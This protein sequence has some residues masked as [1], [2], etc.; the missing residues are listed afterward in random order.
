MVP[1][2]QLECLL[3]K[4]VWLL[5]Q[6]IYLKTSDNILTGIRGNGAIFTYGGFSVAIIWVQNAFFLLDSHS[7]SAYVFHDPSGH[8]ILFKFSSISY[9]K[10][11]IKLFY[12]N[13]TSIFF[14]TQYGLQLINVEIMKDSKYEVLTTLARKRKALYY[15]FSVADNDLQSLLKKR[16]NQVYYQ[17]NRENSS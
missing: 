12:G 8:A 6:M 14:V 13:S 9:L 2:F 5:K 4:V 3:G 16:K 7:Q 15:G 17:K 1:V 10:N 11:C